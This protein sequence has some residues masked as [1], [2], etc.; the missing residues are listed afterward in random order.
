MKANWCESANKQS[1]ES[2]IKEFYNVV[3]PVCE[4]TKMCGISCH[5]EII[6]NI[7]IVCYTSIK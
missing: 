2:T 7:V 1:Y 4:K 5:R 6:E 3:K